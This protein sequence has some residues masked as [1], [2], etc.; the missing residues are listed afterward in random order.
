MVGKA[1]GETNHIAQLNNSLRPC[2]SRLVRQTL[3]FSKQESMLN[4]HF[5][6]FAYHYNLE[7]YQP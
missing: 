5:K 3:S 7:P 6:R 4:L 1:Y 2:I